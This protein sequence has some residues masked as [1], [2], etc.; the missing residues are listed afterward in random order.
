L[1]APATPYPV[2][3]ADNGITWQKLTDG[4]GFSYYDAVWGDGNRL[5]T[6]RSFGLMGKPYN[7][8]YL[9]S[10]ESD[11]SKWAPYQ[12]GA[13]KFGNGP[14]MMHFDPINRIMYSA[15]WGAGFWA[16]KVLDP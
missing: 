8:P 9:T 12:G 16:L 4:I 15:N 13:Q 7:D 3:S 10:P 5:Y 14:Y 11:G 6:M 2:R 1:Y